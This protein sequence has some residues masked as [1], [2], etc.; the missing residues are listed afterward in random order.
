MIRPATPQ[1]TPKEPLQMIE[2]Y[3]LVVGGDV[4]GSLTVIGAA[5]YGV[6]VVVCDKGGRIERAGSVGCGVDHQASLGGHPQLVR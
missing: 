4:S 6:R 3:V 1:P 5:E 2:T